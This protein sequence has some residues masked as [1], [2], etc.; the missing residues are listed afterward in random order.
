MSP[1][2]SLQNDSELTVH[3]GASTIICCGNSAEKYVHI[4]QV[5]VSI[6]SSGL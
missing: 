4:L 5:K 1:Y 2:N 6:V 3:R